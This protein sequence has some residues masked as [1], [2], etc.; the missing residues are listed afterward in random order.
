MIWIKAP[1][2]SLLGSAAR[3]QAEVTID[4]RDE[5]LWFEVPNEYAQYLVDDRADAFIVAFVNYAMRHGHDIIC[6]AP[7]SS[8]LFYQLNSYYIP[9]LN[10][11][12][13]RFWT[14]KIQCGVTDRKLEN[15]RAVGTGMSCGVDAFATMYLHAD[16]NCPPNYRITHLTYF[17]VG[18]ALVANRSRGYEWEDIVGFSD[19]DIVKRTE[20]INQRRFERAARFAERY[21]YPLVRVESNIALVQPM[22]FGH[23]FTARSCAAVLAL[24]KLFAVYCFAAGVHPNQFRIMAEDDVGYYDMLSLPLFSTETTQFYSAGMAYSRIQKTQMVSNY[25][26]SY[27]FLNV[28]WRDDANCGQCPKCLRTLLALDLLGVLDRY[29]TVFDVH[30]YKSHREQIIG[31]VYANVDVDPFYEEIKGFVREN[32]HHWNRLAVLPHVLYFRGRSVI[33]RVLPSKLKPFLKKHV[34]GVTS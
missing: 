30:F 17:N 29:A 28:C 7:I 23:N 25:P 18:G 19:P 2:V 4:G 15:A 31:R 10:A 24:Q 21:G 14:I 20:Y 33:G 26:P 8:K 22:R 5:L 27:D 6:E 12:D 1:T 16:G 32:G 13:E 3:L 11:A 9:A 34:F